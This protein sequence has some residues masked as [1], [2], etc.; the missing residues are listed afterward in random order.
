MLWALVRM[1]R[2]QQTKCGIKS[3]FVWY[4][5][6]HVTNA[7]RSIYSNLKN[8]QVYY[9]PFLSTCPLVDSVTCCIS[10]IHPWIS[11]GAPPS[12]W[13]NALCCFVSYS[14]AW[15]LKNKYLKIVRQASLEQQFFS[16]VVVFIVFGLH[17]HTSCTWLCSDLH[18][19]TQAVMTAAV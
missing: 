3:M 14:P 2:S 17:L 15:N 10:F 5:V 4:H 8:K 12:L 11:F 16:F 1:P 19:Y 6:V 13:D 7:A 9:V 18:F